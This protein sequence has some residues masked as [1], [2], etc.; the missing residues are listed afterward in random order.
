MTQHIHYDLTL[1]REKITGFDT[2]IEG[3]SG[4]NRKKEREK[5]RSN[6]HTDMVLNQQCSL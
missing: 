1:Y 2:S 5:D 6:T 3:F 4:N